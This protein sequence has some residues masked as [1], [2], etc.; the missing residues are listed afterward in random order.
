[1]GRISKSSVPEEGSGSE[2]FA[3]LLLPCGHVAAV[4]RGAHET[5]GAGVGGRRGQHTQ[6]PQLSVASDYRAPLISLINVYPLFLLAPLWIRAALFSASSYII[7]QSYPTQSH[8][9]TRL[10]MITRLI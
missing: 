7:H 5:R 3:E 2:L 6:P 9:L 1:M 8:T 10:C 4:H